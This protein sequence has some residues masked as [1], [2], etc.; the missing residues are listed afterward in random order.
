MVSILC[1]TKPRRCFHSLQHLAP[2]DLTLRNR[3]HPDKGKVDADG[4]TPD[5]PKHAGVVSSVVAED[6]RE[7]DATKIS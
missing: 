5:D 2:T 4:N 1:R 3:S 6:D 7:D